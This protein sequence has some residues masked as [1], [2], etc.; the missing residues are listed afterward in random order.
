MEELKDEAARPLTYGEKAVGI[1]FNPWGDPEVES[2]KSGY[3]KEIDRMN[4]LRETSQSPEQKRLASVA[5]TQLQIAQM[6]SVKA[7]TWKD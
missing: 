7:L 1:K 2:C 5:I 4:D 3:A 6:C